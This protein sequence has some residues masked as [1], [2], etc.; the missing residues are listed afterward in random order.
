MTETQPMDS[1]IRQKQQAG[2]KKSIQVPIELTHINHFTFGTLFSRGRIFFAGVRFYIF[3]IT[4][5]RKAHRY[6]TKHHNFTLKFFNPHRFAGYLRITTTVVR[7]R[8]NTILVVTNRQGHAV[9]ALGR[10][11]ARSVVG[12]RIAQR[13]LHFL[14]QSVALVVS[15]D[16]VDQ[17]VALAVAGGLHPQLVLL[18]EHTHVAALLGQRVLA[19]VRVRR[20]SLYF[21]GTLYSGGLGLA[22][23]PLSRTHKGGRGVDRFNRFVSELSALWDIAPQITFT[24][25]APSVVGL[26]HGVRTGVIHGN[27]RRRHFVGH[28]TGRGIVVKVARVVVELGEVVVVENNP[29]VV[30][31]GPEAQHVRGVVRARVLVTKFATQI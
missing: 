19:V 20:N 23:P 14:D 22:L 1:C 11:H 29:V 13:V 17:R 5:E 15:V 2:V 21:H 31:I 12:N 9:V 30:G 4:R 6:T 10:G 26:A 16:V 28:A 24:S 8:G 7:R 25:L 27:I 3:H 18:V